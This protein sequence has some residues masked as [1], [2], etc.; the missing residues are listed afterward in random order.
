MFIRRRNW[1]FFLFLFFFLPA[2]GFKLREE[3]TL[4][5]TRLF[6]SGVSD[7][8]YIFVG[9]LAR[10]LSARKLAILVTTASDGDAELELDIAQ[11][12]KALSLSESGA[13]QEFI[14]T[15]NLR[16]VLKLLPTK[17]VIDAGIISSNRTMTYSDRYA[18]AKEIER[19]NLYQDMIDEVIN[20]LLWRLSLSN[21][22]RKL[23]L[24]PQNNQRILLS[25]W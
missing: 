21:L 24:L 16:Y 19:V 17:V 1:Y 5:F 4:P 14:F 15:I 12:R 3:C 8:D 2:C 25:P 23:R 18:L 10:W 11:Q 20:Q 6:V 13:L 22:N 7:S 9:R